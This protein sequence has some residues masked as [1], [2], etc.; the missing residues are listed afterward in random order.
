M[1]EL[2]DDAI[3]A[4]ATLCLGGIREE[5]EGSFYPAT[6]L[7]E[8]PA[9]SRI[10]KEEIFGPVVAIQTFSTDAEAI[11]PANDTHFGLAAYV[12]SESLERALNVAESLEVGMVSINKGAL[13][14][15]AAPFWRCE[16][17]GRRPRGRFRGDSR[18][19]GNQ[20]DFHSAPLAQAARPQAQL[21][22]SV[23][24][25]KRRRMFARAGPSSP[26]SSRNWLIM[27]SSR[28]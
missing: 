21:A 23:R 27:A 3:V 12:F 1:A 28:V 22:L 2:V 11:R 26:S 18:I 5:G 25:P 4:G 6:V 10:A 16:G 7:T 24:R 13:S 20:A 15:P 17:V 8:V 19:P 9:E 14:D